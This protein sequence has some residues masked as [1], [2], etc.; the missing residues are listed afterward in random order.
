[1]N[2]SPIEKKF[3]NLEFPCIYPIIAMGLNTPEFPKTTL[4]IL[5]NNNLEFSTDEITEKKSAQSKY[6]SLTIRVKAQSR[7]QLE[8]AYRDLH[9]SKIVH[10]LL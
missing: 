7:Q 6:L 9:N 10:Y 5:E 4:K 8:A 1:M 3:D 2:D